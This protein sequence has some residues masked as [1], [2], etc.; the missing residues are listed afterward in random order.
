MATRK[1]LDLEEEVHLI[2]EKERGFSHRELKEKVQVS[3]GA[4]SNILKRKQEYLDDYESNQNKKFKRKLKD[5][6]G[7]TINDA[8]YEWFV[9]QRSKKIPVSGPRGKQLTPVTWS[10]VES[11]GVTWSHMESRGVRWSHMKS[12]GVTWSHMKSHGVHFISSEQS[13]SL[14]FLRSN[15]L[16]VVDLDNSQAELDCSSAS[17]SRQ[18]WFLYFMTVSQ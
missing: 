1:D 15:T 8:V 9:A 2:K 12:H 18:H 6:L 11:H 7:Q 17:Y 10:H 14:N 3:L 16:A 4:V 5:E 13:Y